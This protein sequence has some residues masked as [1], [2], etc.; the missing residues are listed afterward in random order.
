LQ[1]KWLRWCADGHVDVVEDLGIADS[2]LGRRLSTT[3]LRH[4][5][6][7]FLMKG[8][9]N[10]FWG[11]VDRVDAREEGAGACGK[12]KGCYPRHGFTMWRRGRFDG[13]AV[14]G[15]GSAGRIVAE[16][17]ENEEVFATDMMSR[18]PQAEEL[19]KSTDDLVG[20]GWQKM[21]EKG[22]Y[23]KY[24]YH[25]LITRVAVLRI[26]EN[27]TDKSKSGRRTMPRKLV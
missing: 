5:F 12:K 3:Q 24:G 13:E 4:I 7:D 11:G 10:N 21:N 18:D 14:A 23:G 8:E 19:R 16:K 27:H 20:D 22:N 15:R 17:R 9:G 1:G 2:D 6:A 25:R 26:L